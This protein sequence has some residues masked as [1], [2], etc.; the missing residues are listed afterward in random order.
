MRNFAADEGMTLVEVMAALALLLV[1]MSGL[2]SVSSVAL[3]I[4]ENQMEQLLGLVWGDNSTDTTVF[5]AVNGAGTGLAQGG[6]SDPAAPA[7]GYVDY[8]DQSGNLL[9]AGAGGAKPAGWFYERVWE[10]TIPSP[11]LKQIKVTA[12]VRWG[13]GGAMAPVS[14]VTALKTWPF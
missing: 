4:T 11:N 14:T 3:K 6:S 1:L 2:M 9:V 10:V 12:T 8:L 5:P 13:F 7:V